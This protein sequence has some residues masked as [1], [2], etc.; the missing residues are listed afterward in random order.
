MLSTGDVELAVWQNGLVDADSA[1]LLV[2]GWGADASSWTRHADL[3]ATEHRVVRV[4]LRGHGRSGIS[5][6]RCTM[7]AM[8]ED[9]VAVCDS[10][11]LQQVVAAG[12]SMGGQIV[13]R[14]AVEHPD[15]TPGV[16]V[17]DPAY[18]ADEQE[19][20]G[21]PGRL[22]GLE[23]RGAA[24]V[25]AWLEGAFVES[26][27]EGLRR[28]IRAALLRTPGRVLAEAFSSMYLDD[29]AFGPTERASSYLANRRCRT[30]GLYSSE[31]AAERER[32]L[33]RGATEVV[34]WPG[35]GHYLHQERVDDCAALL[36]GFVASVFG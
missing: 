9:L 8:T 34:S 26:T 28:Q 7:A 33:S 1:M 36:D 27:P 3:L 18:G 22:A 19:M 16:V 15:L 10:L 35:T 20:N 11:G 14:L 32:W 30:L 12:H 2:H 6:R 4:D 5:S 31:Q 24:S 13:S 23:Q 25:L 17:I 21:A 29:D